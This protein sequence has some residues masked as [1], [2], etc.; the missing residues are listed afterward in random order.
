MPASL[1]GQ[2]KRTLHHGQMSALMPNGCVG[3]L[4]Q[5]W[6]P[7]GLLHCVVSLESSLEAVM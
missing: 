6:L 4:H 1:A 3:S 7:P 5:V 2:K